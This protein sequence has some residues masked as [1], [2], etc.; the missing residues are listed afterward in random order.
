MD[1]DRRGV[2]VG[3]RHAFDWIQQR[4]TWMEHR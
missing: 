2:R 4:I 1:V 3:L